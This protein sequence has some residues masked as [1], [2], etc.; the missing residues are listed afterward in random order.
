MHPSPFRYTIPAS[1]DELIAQ[2][3]D[4]REEAMLL[5]GGQSLIPML[6]LRLFRPAHLIDLGRLDELTGIRLA[7][8]E[9]EPV[10]LV[11]G[12]MTRHA[13]V[14]ASSQVIDHCP[15]LAAAAASIGD[16]HVRNRGT[17]GGNICHGDPGGVFPV[18][19]MALD[20]I[21]TV[22]GPEGTRHAP[23]QEFFIDFLTTDLGP[24]E[25]LSHIA[26]PAPAIPR[27]WA[28]LELRQRRLDLPVLVVGVQ[29]QA[30]SSGAIQQARIVLGGSGMVPLRLE[31]AEEAV[32]GQVPG[33]ALAR[34]AEPLIRDGVEPKDNDLASADYQRE[35]AGVFGRRALIQ[36]MTRLASGEK[37]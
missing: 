5:A 27:G 16:P 28:F 10:G 36:A 17:I 15:L 13:Q 30:S 32:T 19:V 37:V 18:T 8:A 29:V 34:V 1:L 9:E 33:E 14:A 23:A 35:M 3:T 7:Q 24:G 31:A 4:S 22:V 20:A 26:V 2:L 21:L 25:V 11:L 6:K 12:A